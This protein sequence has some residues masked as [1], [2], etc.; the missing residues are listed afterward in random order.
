MPPIYFD[1]NASSPPAP[2]V[3]AA[4][5]AALEPGLGN[6]SSI[7]RWGQA[8]K[9]AVENARQHVAELIGARPAEIVF[10]SGGT[11]SDNLALRGLLAGAGAAAAGRRHIISTRIEHHAV[12]HA[13]ERLE[14]EGWRVTLLPADGEG[15]VHVA[16]LEAALSPETALVSV[17]MANNETGVLQ[18]VAEIAAVARR[19]GVPFH[20]DAVQTVGKLPIDVRA[21]G[22]DAMSFSAHK[23]HGPLGVGGLYVR[24][25]VP[26]AA[27][28]LGGHHERDR[29][30]GSENVPGIVGFGAAAQ[31]AAADLES[32]GARLAALRDR[33]EAGLLRHVPDTR[34]IGGGAARVPNTTNILFTG[35]E[36]EALVIALDL[37]GVCVSTGA[38][39]SSGTI[40]PSH[41]LMAMGLS[42][43]QARS[44]LRFSLGRQNT[45]A[46]VDEV[47]TVLPPLVERLRRLSAPV[48]STRPEARR[49]VI[50][51]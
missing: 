50:R 3:R 12:L 15:R 9:A 45:E 31:L 10:T 41:V 25:G 33:L 27:Q 26:L 7:H 20:T 43:A 39:C 28:L 4:V 44:C 29:R 30:A 16:D 13:C 42:R 2:E 38:A 48:R 36:G 34:V 6:A 49:A 14:A 18:P 19:A 35:V 5:L 51:T 40:E 46:E 37:H 17:M 8:A 1:N 24:R 32:E 47:L 22:C 21:L 11:E 23:L